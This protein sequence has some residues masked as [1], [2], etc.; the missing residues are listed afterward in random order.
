VSLFTEVQQPKEDGVALLRRSSRRREK[1]NKK[2][3]TNSKKEG[4][5]E[6]S[7]V[8]ENSERPKAFSCVT[9]NEQQSNKKRKLPMVFSP[10]NEEGFEMQSQR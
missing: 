8:G 4:I 9:A 7:S 1:G 5:A 10:Q 2:K 6:G 3:V